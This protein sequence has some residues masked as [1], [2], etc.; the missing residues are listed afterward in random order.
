MMGRKLKN[1]GMT[2]VEVLVSMLVLSIAAVTVISAFS[3]AAQVNTKAKRQQGAEALMEN[4]LEYAEAG[5]TDFKTWFNVAATDYQDLSDP[6]NLDEKVEELKNVESG[7]QKYTVKVTTDYAPDE[8]ANVDPNDPNL[9]ETSKQVIQFGGTGSNAILIDATGTSNDIMVRDIFHSMHVSAVAVHNAEEDAKEAEEAA[10]GNTYDKD[11]WTEV[12]A[13][14]VNNMLDREIQIYSEAVSSD[15]YR[16]IGYLVYTVS[17]SLKLGDD[18]VSRTYKIPLCTSEE[19][20]KDGSANPSAKKLTQ[21]Y[22]MYSQ[23]EVGLRGTVDIRVWDPAGMLDVTFYVVKQAANRGVA[24]AFN[25]KLEDWFS[26]GDDVFISCN[27]NLGVSVLPVGLDI[28][29]PLDISCDAY[30]PTNP[31]IKITSNQ[32]VAKAEELKVV[33]I[34]IEVIDP[35]T[36]ERVLES[37]EVTRLQ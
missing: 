8:Y 34:T 9:L 16:I 33:K 21:I 27:N 25:E 4:M 36:G 14:D 1:S 30:G 6:S 23:E 7:F 29:S 20:D 28:Y 32:L 37:E 18:T 5:G 2:L 22:L 12:S 35:V 11:L 13:T 24:D 26:T 3:M 17:D 19:F 31:S 10:L 15:T